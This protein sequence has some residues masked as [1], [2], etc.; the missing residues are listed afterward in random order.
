LFAP[1][2]TAMVGTI[3]DCAHAV[4]AI[5][6]ARA[7]EPSLSDLMVRF[8]K[9]EKSVTKRNLKVFHASNIL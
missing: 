8:S 6:M 3:G 7:T 2:M 1:G 5:G 9:Q 4:R